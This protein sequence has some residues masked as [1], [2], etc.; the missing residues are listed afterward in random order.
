MKITILNLNS[1]Y[2]KN[3][4]GIILLKKFL[5][6]LLIY[7]AFISGGIFLTL[8]II[9]ALM[10]G[11]TDDWEK[12]VIALSKWILQGSFLFFTALYF[13]LKRKKI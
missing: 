5:P 7:I 12:D 8:L 3:Q 4:E 9:T 1:W 6:N 11:K 13:L 10:Y 2:T